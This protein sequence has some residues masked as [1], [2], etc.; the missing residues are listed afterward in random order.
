M[1]TNLAAAKPKIPD[2]C[3]SKWPK[4]GLVTFIA[5]QCELNFIKTPDEMCFVW[6]LTIQK[7]S[8]TT[9]KII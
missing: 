2:Y 4:I 7:Y 6:L 5:I 3:I 1:D 9:H 8:K